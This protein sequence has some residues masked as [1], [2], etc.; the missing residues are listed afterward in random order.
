[1]YISIYIY[2]YIY[3]YICAYVIYI[4]IYMYIVP[5]ELRVLTVNA[6]QIHYQIWQ[7]NSQ[8]FA[9]VSF[10]LTQSSGK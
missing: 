1:M 10:I 7:N 4:Y 3:I 5:I 9:T 6:E 8:L 2:I